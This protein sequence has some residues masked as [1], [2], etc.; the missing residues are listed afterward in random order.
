[1]S[2]CSFIVKEKVFLQ[3]RPLGV[4]RTGTSM[5][6]LVVLRLNLHEKHTCCVTYCRNLCS[7]AG[8][9]WKT[10]TTVLAKPNPMSACALEDLGISC[11]SGSTGLC[12]L[13]LLRHAVSFCGGRI[14]VIALCGENPAVCPLRTLLASCSSRCHNYRSNSEISLS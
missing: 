13:L 4:C 14:H 1:M 5:P 10:Q 6:N 9:A 11:L 2:K 8:S 3:G 7:F 12:P